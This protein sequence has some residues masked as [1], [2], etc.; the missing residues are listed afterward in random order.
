MGKV[1]L[2]YLPLYRLGLIK[3]LVKKNTPFPKR[4]K[5]NLRG[6]ALEV[7]PAILSSSYVN[8]YPGNGTN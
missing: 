2:N 4:K 6:V 8:L 7:E 5:A 3:L 1:G